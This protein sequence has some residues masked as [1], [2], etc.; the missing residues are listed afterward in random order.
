[1]ENQYN[2]ES[3]TS[4]NLLWLANEIFTVFPRDVT[5]LKFYVL[6]CGCIDY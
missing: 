4:D 6:D 2:I 3:S 1:M 5:G